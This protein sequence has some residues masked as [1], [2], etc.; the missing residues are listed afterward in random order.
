MSLVLSLDTVAQI[1]PEAADHGG[2]VLMMLLEAL[3]SPD[4]DLSALRAMV[5]TERSRDQL[6]RASDALL[7]LGNDTDA[8]LSLPEP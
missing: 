8:I 5:S 6:R 3:E 4:G 2:R 1:S 7:A